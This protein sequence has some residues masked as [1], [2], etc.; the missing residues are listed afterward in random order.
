[1]AN[2]TLKLDSE[3][4]IEAIKVAIAKGEES[5]VKMLLTNIIFDELQKEYLIKWAEHCQTPNIV[6]LLKTAPATP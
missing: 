4:N 5:K 6:T 3:S 2:N 1:M